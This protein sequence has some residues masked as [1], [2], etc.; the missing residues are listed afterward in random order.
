EA[1]RALVAAGPWTSKLLPQ[2]DLPLEVERQVMTWLTIDDPASFP[3]HR[4]PVFIRE[5]PVGRFRYGFPSTD[6]RSIKIGVHHEGMS[7]DPDSI[8]RSVVEAD[9]APIR[10][11]TRAHLRGVTSDVV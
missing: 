8:D 10:D 3:P 5:V 7:A 1:E 11:F 4:F 6:G 9:L 2:L